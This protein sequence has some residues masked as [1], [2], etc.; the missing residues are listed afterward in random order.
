MPLPLSWP[1]AVLFWAAFAWTAAGEVPLSIRDH[2]SGT[3]PT[4]RG[5]KLLIQTT[6]GLGALL[7]FVA[8]VWFRQFELRF[9]RLPIYLAGAGCLAVAGVLRRH[10]FRALGDS[11]TFD[12]RIS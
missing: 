6:S 10:C 4:D 3:A 1:M 11:F 8:A 12:V 9:L 5:S 7:A 2:R